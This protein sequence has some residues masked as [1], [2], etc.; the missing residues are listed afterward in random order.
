MELHK[1]GG[2][3]A[4]MANHKVA[5][6]ILMAIFLLGG[7]YFTFTIKKEVF[8]Q[9][10]LDEI[11]ISIPYPGATPEEVEQGIILAAEEAI[12]DVEG[13]KKIT[14]SAKE[15]GASLKLELE[16]GGDRDSIYQDVKQ[17]IDA[18]TTFPL[19]AEKPS[20]S[21]NSRKSR[22]LTLA[23]FGDV[24]EWT[25]RD[26]S[27][28][29]R[30]KLLAHKEITQVE[31]SGIRA[32]EIRIDVDSHMLKNLGLSINDL[33]NII[34]KY[35]V[36]LSG[37]TI[38]N[39][40]G[41]IL[42]RVNE[43]RDYPNEFG[44]IPIQKTQ[45]GSMVHLKDVAK[46]HEGF[47]EADVASYY[48]SK[49]SISFEVYRVGDQ[50]PIGVSDA[51]KEVLL[52]VDSELPS[53][54][55]SVIIS[56]SADNYRARLELLL[57]NGF[58][59]LL[60]VGVILGIFLEFRLA[61]WVALGI[62]TSFLGAFLFLPW[63]DVSVNMLSMFAFIIALG[64]VVDD[65][66]IAGENIYEYRQRGHS[67]KEAAILGAQSIK[68]PL[69]YAII[70]NI[71][72]FMPLMFLPGMMGKL[73]L[74]VPIVVA[75]VFAIS[76][77]EALYILPNHLAFSEKSHSSRFSNFIYTNQQKIASGL[78]VFIYKVYK[79][80]IEFHIRYRY[81]TIAF[82]VAMLVVMLAYASSGRLGF[83]MMPR[84]ESDR[85]VSVAKLPVGST[86]ADAKRVE[87]KIIEGGIKTVEQYGR[88]NLF[89]GY[90][91]DINE[92]SVTVIFYLKDF[93]VRPVSTLS[94]NQTWRKH[95][96]QIPGVESVVYKSDIGGPGGGAAALSLELSHI[97]HRIL[98]NS[99]KELSNKLKEISILKDINNG[100]EDGKKQYEITLLP[101]ATNLGLSSNDIARQ[102]RAVF[103][104]VE[105]LAQQR[106]RNE[107]SVVL[108]Y[109]E[110]TRKNPSD[111]MF[112]EIKSPSGAFVP[113]YKVAELKESRSYSQINRSEGR[114]VVSVE[115]NADPERELPTVT[116]LLE[117]EILPELKSRYPGL[118]INY[119]GRQA[120]TKESMGALGASFLMVLAVI[121]VT[122]ALPFRSYTQPLIVMVAIPFGVI[123]A[124]LGH[125][126]MGYSLSVISI[127]GIV[128]LCGVVINDTLIM[129][130][131]ANSQRDIGKSAYESIVNAGTRRFRPIILTTA[132]TF[133]GLAPMIFEPSVQARFMIPMA[134]SLGYGILF[135]TF[136]TLILIPALYMVLDDI[137]RLFRKKE[138]NPMPI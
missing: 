133:G 52:E 63:F 98:E 1:G 130:D 30:D 126:L 137:A 23:I 134:I 42:L 89:V 124:F 40:G 103:N 60:L 5:A 106:G 69:S 38:K 82:G 57:K 120:D 94:F 75:T 114:R 35:S 97:D 53:L 138:S 19:D 68:V 118:I 45:S 33:S 46:I 37:G 49:R 43:R 50:T 113:L 119:Q 84:V 85:A 92:N 99:A 131:Y 79:P 31:M 129:I 34:S 128:A 8:P 16:E 109:P 121:Y 41:E 26:I 25:L 104:G 3:I 117:D 122:L 65:A 9:F 17:K 90:R 77:I 18:I 136:I 132:T 96:G 59:G 72:A 67:Y 112:L 14:S 102:I 91:S 115:A 116:K 81:V 110:E 80:V 48:N 108:R 86:M 10:D 12:R 55:E 93:D 66:I 13:I 32:M 51:V 24:D 15:G 11:S 61:F 88:E 58:I 29:V 87:E 39:S 28:K 22:V 62:P 56:D 7:I 20:V 107:I 105:A 47:S 100:L 74:V 78:N 2:S 127:M 111:L 70:T 71:F 83:T 4:W 101:L 123:G 44:A 76:W 54:V 95:T 64:I 73:F 36:E 6:N 27:E 135:A 21:I 125:M